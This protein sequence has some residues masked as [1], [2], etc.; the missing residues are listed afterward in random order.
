MHKIKIEVSARHCHLSQEHLDQLFGQG[1]GLVR[2]KDLSQPGQFASQETVILRTPDGQIDNLRVLGP[3]RP[4]T[5]VELSMTD[6]R[7]LKI[8]PP[9]RVSGDIKGSAG[10]TLIGP[11][12]E[13]ELQEGIIIAQRHIHAS[14]KQA[15]KLGLKA[16][17]L[18][19]VKTSGGRSVTF[20]D[21]IIRVEDHFDLSFQ[22]DTDEGN[23]SL[24]GGVCSEGEIIHPVE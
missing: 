3:V 11:M 4:D 14:S 22:I 20:H 18:V 1:H 16:G 2:M 5:Q 6:V 8:S 17:Q 7:K 15:E 19:S 21:V 9:I 12:G 13:V 24:P 23:A 10:A